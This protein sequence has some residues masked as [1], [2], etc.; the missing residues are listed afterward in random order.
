MFRK[1]IVLLILL[2][3]IAVPATILAQD[4]DVP[5]VAII[6]LG[7]LP[8]FEYSQ[9]GTLDVLEAY[10]YVDGENINLILGDASMDVPTANLLI[11]DAINEDVDV[12]IT[13]TTPVTQAAVNATLE[14]EDP[15]IVLFNTVTEPYAAGI[16]DASCIKP[17][18]VWGSQALPDFATIL[19][20]VW[21]LDPDIERVGWIFSTTEPNGVASTAIAEPIAEE[22]GLELVIESV[23]ETAEVGVAAEA[24][25]GER[26]DAFFIPTDSTVGNG[27]ASILAVA[28]EEGIPVFFADSLQVFAGVTVG[29]G[30]SYYQ[31]GV[32]TGRVLV[33][34]LNGDIDIATTGL[35]RQQG[36]LVGV[37]LDTADMQDVEIPEELLDRAN[38]VIEDGE[39]IG[40]VLSLPDVSLE[41]LQEMDAEFIESLFCSEERIAEQE[42]ELESE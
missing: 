27:L 22:I 41:E 35:S 36:T 14:M 16:A 21:E 42:A 7:P 39:N 30:V 28:E 5:S 31:E 9:Q 34:Y 20:M 24:I 17:D 13:I 40:D 2:T 19:P 25:A 11:E 23:A 26:V 15:P 8:P 4:D 38:F 10:G 12:I 33:A 6:R 18:H 3:V 37:N 1:L 29:A 32:D